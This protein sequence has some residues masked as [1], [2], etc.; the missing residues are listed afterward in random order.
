MQN[1]LILSILIFSILIINACSQT[2]SPNKIGLQ[3]QTRGEAVDKNKEIESEGGKGEIVPEESVEDKIS[4]EVSEVLGIADKKVKSI[5]Y[6]YKGPETKDFFYEF[7]VKENKI[8]YIL[9]PTYKVIGA[10]D[11]AYDTIYLNNELKKA[12]GYCDNRKCIGKG[13]K[14]DLVYDDVYIWTPFDWLND[15]ESAEKVGEELIDKRSTWKLSTNKFIIWIDTF[16]GVPLQVEFRDNLYHFE[17]I[18]FNQVKDEDVNP[19]G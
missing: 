14:A 19:K 7:F 16:F 9:D 4:S 3:E 6:K 17:K 13:K 8:K 2:T 5:S 1:K 11:D 12:E 10:D 15:I 18:I